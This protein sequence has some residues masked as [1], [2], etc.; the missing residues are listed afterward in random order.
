MENYYQIIGP[1]LEVFWGEIRLDV[2]TDQQ[3]GILTSLAIFF[4][5][6]SS[7]TRLDEKKRKLYL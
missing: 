1:K 5:N 7:L 2:D 6:E 4:P 3:G